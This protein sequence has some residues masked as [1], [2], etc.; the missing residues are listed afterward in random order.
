[1]AA[2]SVGRVVA[3]LVVLTVLKEVQ[4]WALHG[5]RLFDGVSSLEFLELVRRWLTAG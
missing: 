4:E 1:V 2:W 3:C 5:A